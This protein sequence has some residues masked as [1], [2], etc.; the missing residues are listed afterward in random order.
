MLD[1]GAD[2]NCGVLAVSGN[3]P[4]RVLPAAPKLIGASVI[5]A[6]DY[7]LIGPI[8]WPMTVA[9]VGRL[10]SKMGAGE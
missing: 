6:L 4:P 3:P 1:S 9:T 8:D 5:P 2:F 10:T 7:A